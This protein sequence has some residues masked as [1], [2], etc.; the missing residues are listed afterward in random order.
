MT[1]RIYERT[2]IQEFTFPSIAADSTGG[3]PL[4]FEDVTGQNIQNGILR[5]VSA[6]CGSLD[7]DVSLR[8]KSNALA[9]TVNEIYRVT[10]INKYR[11]DDNLHQGWVNRDTPI[12]SK[13]YL[14]LVNGDAVNATGTITVKI[15]AEINRRFQKNS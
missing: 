2:V 4:D 3:G 12:D 14:T 7:F 8:S 15:I 9:D 13:L 1:I 10:G 5:G 6:A 11:S